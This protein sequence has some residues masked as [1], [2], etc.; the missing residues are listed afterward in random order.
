[1]GFLNFEMGLLE[2][3]LVCT[4][5]P[6]IGALRCTLRGTSCRAKFTLRTDHNSFFLVCGIV[7]NQHTGHPP[8]LADEIRNCKHFLDISTLETVAAMSVANIQPAQAA[9]FTK[10]PYW[11]DLYSWSDGICARIYKNGERLDGFPPC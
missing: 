8:L 9:L 2:K 11:S 3:I 4:S 6:R 7:D 10:N 1:M 5:Q